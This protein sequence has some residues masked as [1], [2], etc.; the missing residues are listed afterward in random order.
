MLTMIRRFIPI[1]QRSRP[2]AQLP[3]SAV[4]DSPVYFRKIMDRERYRADRTGIPVSM[5]LLH[6]AVQGTLPE[7]RKTVELRKGQLKTYLRNRLRCTDAVGMLPTGDL[8]ALLPDTGIHGARCVAREVAGHYS[9]QHQQPLRCEI[10]I[11]PAPDPTSRMIDEE[12]TDE[13]PELGP[14]PGAAE[15]R[16]ERRADPRSQNE[17]HDDRDDEDPPHDDIMRQPVRTMD[18]LFQQQ[19]PGWKRVLD[20]LLACA[21]LLVMAPILLTAAAAIRLTSAGPVFF[22]QR[23]AGLGG[24]PFKIYKFRTM[25]DNAEDLKAALRAQSE[26]DGPAFKMKADP[27]VTWVGRILRRSSIDELPQLWN[28]LRGEMTIV[29]PRPL[30]CEESQQ[31]EGWRKRRLDVTPGLTCIWQLDGGSKVSFDEWMRMDIRYLSS[32]ALWSD[33]YLI[34]RTAVKVITHRASI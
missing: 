13:D 7:D 16:D 26:Q 18:E 28:V 19:L 3:E 5:L 12:L 10:F 6:P 21:T 33:L 34:L 23:R 11:Y 1:L 25:Y 29:G 2:A 32:Y 14:P 9:A 17:D 24:K 30:P 8:A 20:I 31:C 4:E 27:R 15:W 22:R